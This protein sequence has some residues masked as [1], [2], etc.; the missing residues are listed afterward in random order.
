MPKYHDKDLGWKAI[1][2]EM[3]LL[4]RVTVTVGIHA[5]AGAEEGTLIAQY[6]AYNEYGA[7]NVP[8]RSFLRS[9][10]D[11]KLPGLN[12]LK[13]KLIKLVSGGK[14]RA[15]KAADLIGLQ[16]ASDVQDKIVDL[17]DPPNSP[18]TIAMKGSSNPLIDQG[19]MKNA[20]RHEVVGI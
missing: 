2:K 10:F 18:V 7:E 5:D 13:A 19:Y 4:D 20:V 16:H 9:T 17:R 3:G 11:D 1:K 8:E 14:L 12:R 15:K 6:A